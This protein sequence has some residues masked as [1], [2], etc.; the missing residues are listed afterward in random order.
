MRLLPVRTNHVRSRP[1]V[2]QSQAHRRRH[3]RR[4]G[5]KHLPLWNLPAHPCRHSRRCRHERNAIMSKVATK[6]NSPSRRKFLKTSA[7]ASG[8]LVLG[9][10]LPSALNSAFA[11]EATTS[12]PN[13][14]IKIGSD[15]TVTILSSH[16][17][18]GQGVY[19][20]MPTLR[21]E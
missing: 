14:W 7:A 15:N 16:S 3:R 13:A 19:T 21:A 18:M 11:A 12:M 5:G 4:D 17:E 2:D 20:S 10:A 8:G 6:L 9:I 1:A